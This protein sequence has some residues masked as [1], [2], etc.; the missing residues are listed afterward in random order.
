MAVAQRESAN[1]SAGE[2]AGSAAALIDVTMVALD[3]RFGT[4]NE[5]LDQK[6]GPDIDQLRP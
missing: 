2:F 1:F 3:L 4:W 5:F 6:F